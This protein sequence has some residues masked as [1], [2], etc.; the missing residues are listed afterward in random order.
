VSLGVGRY[1]SQKAKSRRR[2]RFHP[3][4]KVFLTQISKEG[5]VSP[6]EQGIPGPG[7]PNLD[8]SQKP[9]LEGGPGG[10]I[11]PLGRISRPR[12]CKEIL[13]LIS[14]FLYYPG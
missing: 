5:K 10:R 11:L 7:P 1:I 13:I 12:P 3:R 4:N 2:V 9:S 8:F 6:E 14:F